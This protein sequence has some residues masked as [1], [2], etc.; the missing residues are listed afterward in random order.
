MSPFYFWNK[1]LKK[2][3]GAAILNSEINQSSKV[4]AGSQVVDSTMDRYSFCGYDCKIINCQIGAFCS[5]A[6]GVII[7]GARHPME[8]GSTSPVFCWGRNSV[9]KKFA[10][11]KLPK[12]PR[13]IIGND[14]WIGDRAIIKAGVTI[15]DGAVIGM[16]SV[17]TKNIDS[18]EIWGGNPAHLIRKRFPDELIEKFVE[19]QWWNKADSELSK[20]AEEIKLPERFIGIS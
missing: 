2:L 9:R 6:D 14:V 16:G 1:V 3:R 18:Y 13:T 10:E 4:E 15:G 11:F 17:V 7:G 5:I 12:T 8:W 20:M 19:S